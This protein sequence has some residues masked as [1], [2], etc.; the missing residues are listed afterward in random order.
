MSGRY[1]LPFLI[2]HADIVKGYIPVAPTIPPKYDITTVKGSFSILVVWG[3][4]DTM[5]K[6]RSK[7]F[8]DFKGKKKQLEIPQAGHAC[9]LD[10]SFLFHSSILDFLKSIYDFDDQNVNNKN[11]SNN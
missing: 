6:E 2:E 10:D 5:G 9:Y 8:L 11:N 3:A 4:N 7:I 1:S